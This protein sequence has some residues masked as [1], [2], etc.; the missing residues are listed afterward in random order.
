MQCAGMGMPVVTAI[1]V[2]AISLQ[3]AASISLDEGP[4]RQ[5]AANVGDTVV[6]T[7]DLRDVGARRVHW[8]RKETRRYLSINRV[9]Y[10][11]LPNELEARLSILGDPGREQFNLRIQDLKQSDS[12]TYICQYAF[13][14][15]SAVSAGSSTLTV[16]IPPDPGSP[17][18][19][20]DSTRTAG[21]HQVGDWVT[22][23]C[24]STGNPP[25]LV[26]YHRGDSTEV[27]VSS[28]SPV[29]HQ[30]QLVPQDNGVDFTCTMTSPVLSGPRTCSVRPLEIF[31]RVEVKPAQVTAEEGTGA[32]LVCRGIGEPSIASYRWVIRDTVTKRELHR[33]RYELNQTQQS[34]EIL[35]VRENITVTCF[36][37]TPSALSGNATAVI[38]VIPLDVLGFTTVGLNTASLAHEGQTTVASTNTSLTNAMVSSNFSVGVMNSRR[39]ITAKPT[40]ITLPSTS[41]IIAVSLAV[42]ATIAVILCICCLRRRRQRHRKPLATSLRYDKVRRSSGGDIREDYFAVTSPAQIQ[43]ANNSAPCPLYAVPDKPRRGQPRDL[44]EDQFLSSS[45]IPLKAVSKKRRRNGIKNRPALKPPIENDTAQDSTIYIKP[46]KKSKRVKWNLDKNGYSV[47]ELVDSGTEAEASLVYADLELDS[48]AGCSGS[49]VDSIQRSTVGTGDKTIYAQIT[50]HRSVTLDFGNVL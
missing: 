20:V 2:F 43:P 11:R 30:R 5:I 6:F 22:L 4:Q 21:A 15:R 42:L 36:V 39:P 47:A 46:K 3:Y 38:T 33:N 37:T 8:Y 34:L 44:E 25:P 48:S 1:A 10:R 26:T 19:R 29:A 17:E 32:S 28:A 18:C 31:P 50:N 7:C 13:P 49:T 40:G 9:I 24:N 45:G 23:R 16:Y 41:I 14:E 27:L 12:G 35:S